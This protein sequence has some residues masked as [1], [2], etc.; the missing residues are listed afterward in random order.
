M[1]RRSSAWITIERV[2]CLM[3]CKSLRPWSAILDYYYSRFNVDVEQLLASSYSPNVRVILAFDNQRFS[4]SGWINGNGRQR[5]G[6][7]LPLP[8][9]RPF[10]SS[11]QVVTSSEI[12]AYNYYFDFLKN[13]DNREFPL[14]RLRYFRDNVWSLAFFTYC[15]ETYQPCVFLNGELEGTL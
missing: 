7:P 5:D 13:G 1:D 10:W 9:A 4:F 6:K 11:S 12:I 14:G 3:E 15:D 2:G 8:V